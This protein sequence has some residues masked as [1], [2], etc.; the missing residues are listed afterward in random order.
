MGRVMTRGKKSTQGTSLDNP[1]H[2]SKIHWGSPGRV[3]MK[4]QKISGQIYCEMREKVWGYMGGNK[5]QLYPT[6]LTH[7]T[8]VMGWKGLGGMAGVG[9]SSAPGCVRL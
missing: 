1:A 9:L 8:P 4:Y 3:F 7:P 5:C 6:N 2:R